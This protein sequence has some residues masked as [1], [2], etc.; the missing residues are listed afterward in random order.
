MSRT[1]WLD[2]GE[3]E[4]ITQREGLLGGFT[5]LFSYRAAAGRNSP[6]GRTG[7]DG[8]RGQAA[9]TYLD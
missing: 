9:H 2:A 3:L 5:R 6:T 8:V 7:L 1:L 4:Q